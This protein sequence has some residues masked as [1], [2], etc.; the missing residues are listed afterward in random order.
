MGACVTWVCNTIATDGDLGAEGV[1][2]LWA[3]L[4]DDTCVGDVLPAI[5]RYVGE[6]NGR[7]CVGASNPFHMG[8]GGVGAYTLA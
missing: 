4:T 8:S 6:A 7:E 5:D 2:L 3:D 1:S